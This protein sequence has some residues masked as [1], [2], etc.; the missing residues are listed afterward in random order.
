MM[1]DANIVQDTTASLN[2][3]DLN[4]NKEVTFEPVQLSDFTLHFKDHSFHVH[5]AIMAK[6][7]A[8]FSA[9]ILAAQSNESCSLTDACA[10]KQGHRCLT[11]PDVLGGAAFSCKD[12]NLL[13]DHIYD[14]TMLNKCYPP[15][16]PPTRILPAYEVIITPEIVDFF[17]ISN[18]GKAYG[19]C[20]VDIRNNKLQFS[21]TDRD[22][23]N[24]LNSASDTETDS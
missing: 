3:L 9:A 19:R 2:V 10:N 21:Y 20:D 12:F 14:R 13:L 18:K 6:E 23:R 1:S 7:S 22:R 11:L 15:T 24:S 5:S 16:A 4:V 17:P 8:Y